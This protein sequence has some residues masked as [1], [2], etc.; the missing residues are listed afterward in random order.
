MYFS[1]PLYFCVFC[2]NLPDPVPA[3]GRHRKGIGNVLLGAPEQ[4]RPRPG[5][6]PCTI[7]V[8]AREVSPEAR[9]S[10][11]CLLEAKRYK[12]LYNPLCGKSF[13]VP[14]PQRVTPGGPGGLRLQSPSRQGS[15]G[16]K[17][18]RISITTPYVGNHFSVPGYRTPQGDPKRSGRPPAPE[19]L[20]TGIRREQKQW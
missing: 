11:R 14:G 7:P 16:S 1:I 20:P 8:R 12:F 15:A 19:P 17:N 5:R 13:S 3:T 10:P 2:L 18:N 4:S 6:N 9:G